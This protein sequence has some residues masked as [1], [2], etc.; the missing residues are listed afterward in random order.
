M[1]N[2]FLD[3]NILIDYVLNR[4]GGND[5]EQLLMHG[6]KGDVSH[7]VQ[8]QYR[9]RRCCDGGNQTCY[10]KRHARKRMG[11]DA[12]RYA[13]CQDTNVIIDMLLDREDADGRISRM[14]FRIFQL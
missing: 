11:S 1:K 13:I 6:R 10:H 14:L 8:F 12:G 9:H 5:A 2:V 7:Y 3:T 4:P